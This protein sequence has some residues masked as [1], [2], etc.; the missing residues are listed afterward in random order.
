M[1]DIDCHGS[2]SQIGVGFLYG[3]KYQHEQVDQKKRDQITADAD[4]YTFDGT[5]IHICVGVS[6][7]ENFLIQPMMVIVGK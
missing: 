6:S 4:K 5:H 7:I 1:E 2:F 3:R